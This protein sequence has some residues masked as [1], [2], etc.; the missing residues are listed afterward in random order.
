MAALAYLGAAG[1]TGAWVAGV[2]AIWSR[3]GRTD[4]SYTEAGQHGE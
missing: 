3:L 4:T 1:F 2:A